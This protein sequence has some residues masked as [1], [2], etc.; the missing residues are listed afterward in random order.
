MTRH[1]L[2]SNI[3]TRAPR[4]NSMQESDDAQRGASSSAGGGARRVATPP[5]VAVAAFQNNRQ[6]EGLSLYEELVR[7]HRENP[8]E[9]EGQKI[10]FSAENGDLKPAASPAAAQVSAEPR[11]KPK[12]GTYRVPVSREYFAA[13]SPSKLGTNSLNQQ[14]IPE[15]AEDPYMTVGEALGKLK[16]LPL[17]F[18]DSDFH[19]TAEDEAL[20]RQL[21]AEEE[22]R[23]K[24][25]RRAAST[26]EIPMSS[27]GQRHSHK[28]PLSRSHGSIPTNPTTLAG[29]VRPESHSFGHVPGASFRQ[30]GY[31]I[32]H[33]LPIRAEDEIAKQ[34]ALLR[35]I[36]EENERKQI[37]WAMK[38]SQ[39]TA[40]EKQRRSRELPRVP[41]I[42]DVAW[43]SPRSPNSRRNNDASDL[44]WEATQRS[45]LEEYA[46]QQKD[47][48]GQKQSMRNTNTTGQTDLPSRSPPR[49]EELLKRGKEETAK[50]IQSGQA[51]L[52]KCQCCD[53]R[54]RAPVHYS[55]VY[56]PKCGNVSP[57]EP[58]DIKKR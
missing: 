52:V 36:M 1:Q 2:S 29:P 4:Q 53:R 35:K 12:N 13:R 42:T 41:G 10:D 40:V 31:P 58:S 22:E 20:A 19:D 33:E 38:E 46:R 6:E 16:E 32:E 48:N 56:C 55:L 51:V 57:V 3:R 45:A 54:L 49:K 8:D 50:A 27:L 18:L 5:S 15:L 43:D 34:E 17:P 14:S 23:A 30:T 9:E 21:Q 28:Q 24:S 47:L 37:E 26:S 25:S 11:R 44:D 7:Y 39:R